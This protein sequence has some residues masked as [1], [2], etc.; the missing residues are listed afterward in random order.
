M[1]N[2]MYRT[3]TLYSLILQIGIR[4]AA[5]IMKKGTCL[6]T[7]SMHGLSL[8]GRGVLKER[9]QKLLQSEKRNMQSVLC[10]T[11]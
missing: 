6:N 1:L 3:C 2:V 4:H 9:V 8:H 7:S 5:W 10:G 11:V